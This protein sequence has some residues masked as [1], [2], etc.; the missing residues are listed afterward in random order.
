[1]QSNQFYLFFYVLFKI[2]NRRRRIFS[3]N[4]TIK[5]LFEKFWIEL[6]FFWYTEKFEFIDDFFLDVQCFAI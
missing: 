3:C 1:M 2:Q 4:I 6:I 5:V